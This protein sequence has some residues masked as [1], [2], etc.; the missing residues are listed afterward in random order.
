METLSTATVA[1]TVP[2]VKKLIEAIW[3]LLKKKS[4]SEEDLKE[5][6]SK[7]ALLIN[8]SKNTSLELERFIQLLKYSS[9]ASVHSTELQSILES[10]NKEKMENFVIQQFIKLKNVRMETNLRK[11]GVERIYAYREA[12]EKAK[13]YYESGELHLLKAEQLFKTSNI[14][15]CIQEMEYLNRE[16]DNLVVFAR[17]RIDDL[18]EALGEAYRVLLRIK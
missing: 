1:L 18:L 14:S 12:Y 8:L 15:A 3:N 2:V 9:E 16:L 17:R 7:L 10:M 6:R 4:P 11:E 5:L 13:E